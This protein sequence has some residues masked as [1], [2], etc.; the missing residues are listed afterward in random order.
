MWSC[1]IEEI[2]AKDING[3][4]FETEA[5]F[6]FPKLTFLNLCDLP[7]LRSFYPGHILHSGHC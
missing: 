7:Q 2:V 3:V 5:K 6:V 4:L 1:G